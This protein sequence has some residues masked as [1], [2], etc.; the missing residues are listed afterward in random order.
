MHWK[1]ESNTGRVSGLV[2]TEA[3][4]LWVNGTSGAIRVPADELKRWLNDS[5]YGVSANRF[6]IQDGLPRT[7]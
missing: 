7:C 6:D 4:E 3:G 1:D 5:E 2:E